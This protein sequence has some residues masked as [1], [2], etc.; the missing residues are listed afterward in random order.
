MT[1]KKQLIGQWLEELVCSGASNE[2]DD[3]RMQ[4]LLHRVGFPRAVCTCGI[5]YLKGKGTLEAPPTP[6]QS[7]AKQLANVVRR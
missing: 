7:I 5:A 1:T 3:A 6:I 2:Q 4:N